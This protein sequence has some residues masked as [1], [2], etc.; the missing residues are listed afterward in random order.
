MQ[1][2]PKWLAVSAI[3]AILFVASPLSAQVVGVEPDWD[4]QVTA[5]ARSPLWTAGTVMGSYLAI[6]T[7]AYFAWYRGRNLNEE[8]V[9]SD[10]GWFESST[11]AG[12]ADKL[13]H[14][15]SNYLMNRSTTAVLRKGGMRPASSSLLATALTASFFTLIEVKDGYHRGFG[16]SW[17]D[18]AFNTLGNALAITMD[19]GPWLDERFSFR[20]EYLP[21]D[22]YIEML[23]RDGVVD[24]GEDYSG[25][26]FLLAWHLSS[27]GALE[28]A[29][30][31][32][33]WLRYTDLTVGFQTLNYLPKPVD[34]TAVPDQ[35]LFLGLSVNIQRILEEA[36]RYRPRDRV[37]SAAH[38]ITEFYGIPYTTSRPDAGTA[39]GDWGDDF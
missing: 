24:V 31:A 29:G 25:Q 4:R 11:Y 8:L 22:R 13:G 12:G 14:M 15:Y 28:G 9:V 21:T 5:P 2:L 19:N 39:S 3:F 36:W 23:Q 18:M 35:R 34:P 27:L 33:S 17:G 6:Y 16:F 7:W 26:T 32:L 10:E 20:L 38:F 30:P 37:Y 1:F